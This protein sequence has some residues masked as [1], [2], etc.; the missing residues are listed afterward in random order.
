MSETPAV[1]PRPNED[2]PATRARATHLFPTDGERVW[3][4][5]SDFGGIAAWHPLIAASHLEEVPVATGHAAPIVRLLRTV[6][7]AMIREELLERDER[8][9]TLGYRFLD[10][11][12]PV[13]DYRATVVVAAPQGPDGGCEVTWTAQFVP[14]DPATAESLRRTFGDDVFHTGLRSLQDHLG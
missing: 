12:F 6:D 14:H 5:F 8:R 10:S 7:G 13:S 4:A 11:P 1:G 3:R 9:R 2:T